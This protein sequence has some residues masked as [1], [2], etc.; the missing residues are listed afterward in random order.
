MKTEQ[1]RLIMDVLQKLNIVCIHCKYLISVHRIGF[2]IFYEQ[3]G[4]WVALIYT[5]S[6][7]IYVY[8]YIYTFWNR[9][10]FRKLPPLK[11]HTSI[12]S[13]RNIA[14]LFPDYYY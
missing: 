5:L 13:V 9:S 11:I 7:Y 6:E 1:R 8:I 2:K 10:Y 3:E 4:T 12:L 14:M